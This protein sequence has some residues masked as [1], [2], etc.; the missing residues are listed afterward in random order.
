M[1][2]LPLLKMRTASSLEDFSND[3]SSLNMIVHYGTLPYDY[4]TCAQQNKQQLRELVAALW[5]IKN[6]EVFSA[7]TPTAFDQLR[8]IKKFNGA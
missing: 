3:A 8:L 1:F 5:V 7:L 6:T 2:G 4:F